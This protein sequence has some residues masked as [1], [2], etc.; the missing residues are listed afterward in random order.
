MALPSMTGYWAGQVFVGSEFHFP[1]VAQ[2]AGFGSGSWK[3][4]YLSM[5]IDG[6]PLRHL[7]S[8]R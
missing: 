3:M 5:G 1:V 4:L 7:S 6:L 2:T 8:L